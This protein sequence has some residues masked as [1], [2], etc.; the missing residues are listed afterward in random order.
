MYRADVSSCLSRQ[1]ASNDMLDDLKRSIL[2][3]TSDQGRGRDQ[4]FTLVGH[5]IYQCVLMRPA[6]GTPRCV[7]NLIW[8]KVIDKKILTSGDLRFEGPV[9]KY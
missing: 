9:T 5:A 1:G 2:Y 8:S 4:L 6:R 3:L 7:S